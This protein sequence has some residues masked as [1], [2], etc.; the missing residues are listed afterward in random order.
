LLAGVPIVIGTE[1]NIYERK[2]AHHALI[3]RAL[4]A[5][6][7]AVVASAESVKTFYVQQIGARPEKVDVIYSAVDWSRLKTTTTREALRESIGVPADAKVAGIIARL[8]EQKGHRIL[9]DALANTPALQQLHLV[10]VGGGELES[11]LRARVE[12]LRLS[13]RVHFIGPRR[14]LGDLLASWDLF[15]MPSFWEGLPL[16]LILAMGA[17][18]PI[19]TTRVAGLPEIVHDGETGLLVQPGDSAA[20]GVALARV[21][22]DP[23]FGARLGEAARA[24]ALPRFG[25]DG[26]VNAIVALY[27]R[28]LVAKRLA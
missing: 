7:D 17:A 6:T 14:D 8:T 3:E 11:D 1:V 18:L 27:D 16:S 10:V 28:L 23:A 26:Y 25:A 20:L 19:V 4:M 13:E 12:A 22:T 24:F 5:G 2:R 21:V 15:V 9:F